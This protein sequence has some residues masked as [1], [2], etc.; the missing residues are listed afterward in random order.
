M[1]TFATPVS[2]QPIRLLGKPRSVNLRR[3]REWGVMAFLIGCGLVSLVTTVLIIVILGKETWSFFASDGISLWH[4]LTDTHWTLDQPSADQQ[5]GIL[6]LLGGT[7]LVTVVA[8]AVALPLGLITAIW[9]S[10]YAH[11]RLRAVLKPVLEIL[12]G[13]PTVVFGFFAIT[14]I[15]P[16][17]RL[18]WLPSEWLASYPILQNPLGI[19]DFNALSAGIAVGILVLP[20]IVSLV[21]DSLR[22]VPRALREGSYGLGA[23]RLETS[24]KIVFPAA[25]SGV[26]AACLLAIARAVGETM[27]VALA[28]GS[29]R[30]LTADPRDQVQP[31]T[32]Y[33]VQQF[34][35]DGNLVGTSVYYSCYAV[36]A[37]LFIM[38]FALTIVGHII[39]VRFRQEYE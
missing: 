31:I 27:I 12:A 33:M 6:P 26:V 8:M 18:E 15:T 24:I 39:R 37:A 2:P 17:L 29:T 28:A 32:G 35:G 3:V 7:M 16:G 10:E 23:T 9:L 20:I 38:T 11:P 25:L 14:V 34:G 13:I 5:Y 21:E 22:A 36:A 30:Q 4:F 1:T 19:G